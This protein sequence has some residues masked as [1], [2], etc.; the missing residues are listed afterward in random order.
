MNETTSSSR[1]GES[2]REYDV[3]TSS[4]GIDYIRGVLMQKKT[5][6]TQATFWK[7]PHDTGPGKI[8]LRVGRYKRAAGQDVP[9]QTNPKSQ[10]TLEGNELDA[11][12]DFIADNYK[13][14]REGARRYM[15]LDQDSPQE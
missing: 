7:I 4:K 3:R 1:T 14:L 13:P 9:A 2:G 8:S 11:L 6:S 12:I 10:L 15:V 5:V